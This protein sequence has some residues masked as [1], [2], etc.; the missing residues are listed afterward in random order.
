MGRNATTALRIP[1]TFWGLRLHPIATPSGLPITFALGGARADE[2]DICSAMLSHAQIARDGQTIMADKGYRSADFE[3]QLKAAGISLIRPATNPEAP[4][5]GKQFLKALRQT[6][7]SVYG[8][9]KD[10]NATADA[11]EPVSVYAY[12]NSYLP[13]PRSSGT[14]KPPTGLA[15]PADDRQHQDLGTDH[16]AD[17]ALCG[18][19]ARCR[20]SGATSRVLPVP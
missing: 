10:S 5:A 1:A 15:R 16:L 4:R 8:T 17:P 2:R 18:R 19:L 3:K 9:L 11:P 20:R 7:E 12:S 13:S 14:T 6:I